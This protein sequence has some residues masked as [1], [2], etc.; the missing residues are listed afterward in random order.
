MG[1]CI[2]AAGRPRCRAVE[3]LQWKLPARRFEMRV[4]VAEDDGHKADSDF[5]H[6]VFG[7]D[8]YAMTSS[9]SSD[10]FSSTTNNP[11][12]LANQREF[13]NADLQQPKN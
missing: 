3:W 2:A 11:A 10:P 8:L 4:A 1:T 13:R 5:I 12:A 6:W 7:A 9:M